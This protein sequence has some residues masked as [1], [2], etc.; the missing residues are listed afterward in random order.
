MRN[1]GQ[2]NALMAGILQAQYEIIVTMDDDL[3]HPPEEIPKLLAEIEK[4]FD[5]VYGVPETQRHSTIRILSSRFTK[6]M[7]GLALNSPNIAHSGAFRAF[8]AQVRDAFRNYRSKFVS[9]DV[10]LEWGT[11]KFSFVPVRHDL[12]YAGKTNYTF[13]K[14]V[15]HTL[16]MVTGFQHAAATPG[17]PARV[18]FYD[19][20]LFGADLCYRSIYNPG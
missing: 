6:W 14:L 5:V 17:Q 18:Y 16:N 15:R 7:M 10:L 13:R 9:I 3:Q 12:R 2:H 4:G 1:Y 19:F 11:T 8:R 20:R